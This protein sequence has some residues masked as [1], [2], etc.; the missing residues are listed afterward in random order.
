MQ[1]LQASLWG[2]QRI[3]EGEVQ[4]DESGRGKQEGPV[5]HSFIRKEL[6]KYANITI[7]R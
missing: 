2:T 1:Q 3:T 7:L 6:V 5:K 4:V